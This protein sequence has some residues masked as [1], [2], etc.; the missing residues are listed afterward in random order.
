[1]CVCVCVFEESCTSFCAVIGFVIRFLHPTSSIHY[2]QIALIQCGSS[3]F[4]LSFSLF[5]LFLSRVHSNCAWESTE[6]PWMA[7]FSFARLQWKSY[8]PR[9]G[10]LTHSPVSA[11]ESIREK[12]ESQGGSVCGSG[13]SR[14]TKSQEENPLSPI[15]LTMPFTKF[16]PFKFI[17]LSLIDP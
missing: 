16:E 5:F 12:E 11:S 14:V 6:K 8:F 10:L 7:F 15:Q 13:D 17:S 9:L 1:M 4:L 2:S 3:S